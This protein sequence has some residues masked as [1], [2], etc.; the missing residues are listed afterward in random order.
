MRGECLFLFHLQEHSMESGGEELFWL[1]SKYCKCTQVVI[2]CRKRMC[3]NWTEAC[4]VSQREVKAFGIVV[5]LDAECAS[6]L[7][8]CFK[9]T[10]HCLRSGHVAEWSSAHCELHCMCLFISVAT[11]S[12]KT[13]RLQNQ[14]FNGVDTFCN[15]FSSILF[16]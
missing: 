9:A 7:K 6:C 10:A 12:T 13:W 5:R 16:Q 15:I 14:K 4:T 8:Q 3:W 11:V 1:E 2:C